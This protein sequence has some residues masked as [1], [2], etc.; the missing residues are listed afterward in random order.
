MIYL[1]SVTTNFG[2]FSSGVGKT[3]KKYKKHHHLLWNILSVSSPNWPVLVI[4]V[5]HKTYSEGGSDSHI[6]RY[7]HSSNSLQSLAML[8]HAELVCLLPK[9]V[10]R[11]SKPRV[12]LLIFSSD[13]L[14]QQQSVAADVF[15]R[16]GQTLAVHE[17]ETL[18]T[19]HVY[20]YI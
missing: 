14:K 5:Q 8:P 18:L 17:T 19:M 3:T 9:P 13:S 6:G 7:P 4:C 15:G 1:I 11:C 10:V 12:C 20:I 16:S 2:S